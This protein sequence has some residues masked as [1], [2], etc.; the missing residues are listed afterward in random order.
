MIN[1]LQGVQNSGLLIVCL[2]LA[3]VIAI[4]FATTFHEFA[5]AYA[6]HKCGDDTAKLLGRMSLNPFKHIDFLGAVLFVF[7]GFGWAKPVPINPVRFRNY[8]KGLFWTSIAGVLANIILAIVSSF[9][10]FWFAKIAHL[11]YFYYFMYLLFSYSAM[12]NISFALFNLLPIYPLDGFNAVASF[13]KYDN[14]FVNF[15]R[16]YG[17]IVLM[18]LLLTGLFNYVYIYVVQNA[19]FGL[20]TLWGLIF[21]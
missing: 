1:E 12:L 11:N 9:I 20:N 2:F 15:M 6:A 18:V 8:K 21:G 4:L 7:F 16:Q 14:K 10:L 3:Y 17:Y 13:S 5:H 19:V